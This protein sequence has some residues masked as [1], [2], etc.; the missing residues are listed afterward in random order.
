MTADSLVSRDWS[1]L[2]S[3]PFAAFA[4]GVAGISPTVARLSD[5]TISSADIAFTTIVISSGYCFLAFLAALIASFI[6][7]GGPLL[8][9]PFLNLAKQRSMIAIAAIV[10]ALL[11]KAIGYA[12]LPTNI[13]ASTYIGAGAV[14]FL[15]KVSDQQ[16]HPTLVSATKVAFGGLETTAKEKLRVP[17]SRGWLMGG[18]AMFTAALG[19]WLFRYDVTP[20]GATTI[21][22]HDRWTGL[23]QICD[24]FTC[25]EIQDGGRE[26]MQAS[27]APWEKYSG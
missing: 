11:V 6:V 9:V 25:V 18:A 26:A 7:K 4:L 12:T 13:Y 21:I 14:W 20:S 16:E 19:L 27:Q 24:Q 8:G 23:T 2:I 22:K 5:G 17:V 10:S 3:W 1:R 15:R